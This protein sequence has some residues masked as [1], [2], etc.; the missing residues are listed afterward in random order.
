MQMHY[1]P[2]R[3]TSR[4]LGTVRVMV[5]EESEQVKGHVVLFVYILS[6]PL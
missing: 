3:C 2:Y 5:E 1:G 4:L 6:I